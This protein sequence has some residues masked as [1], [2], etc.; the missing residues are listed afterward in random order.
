MLTQEEI[1]R[2][3]YQHGRNRS[4]KTISRNEEE[5]RANANPYA[6]AIYRRF[7]LPLADMIKK[8][9]SEKRTGR[10]QAHVQLLA[11]ID[12]LA[13]AFIAVRGVLNA[14][15]TDSDAGGR[16]VGHTV[17]A[18]VYHEYCLSVFHEA[19]P[20]LFFAITNDLG[21]RMSKS[22][23]H[24]MTVYKMSAKA[25]GVQFNEWGQG[26]VDQVG[27]YLI[28]CLEQLGMVYT[29]TGTMKRGRGFQ[30]VINVELSSEVLTIVSRISDR[31]IETTPYFLPCVEKPKPWVSLD[32]GG[33]HTKEM[34]RLHPFMIRCRPGQ[35]D[36]FRQADLSKEMECINALQETAWRVNKRLLDTVKKVSH[37]FDM[38][39]ILSMED[40]PPPERPGFLDGMKEADMS[41]DQLSQFKAWKRDMASWHTEMKLRGTRYG[42]FST[43]VRVANQFVD[44][45]EL[46][47]VYF[48]DFRGRKYV[49]TTGISPQG[50][51]LQKALLEFAKGE[52][53]DTPE[54]V[55]W[56][57]ILGANKWG[58]DKASLMD[59]VAWVDSHHDQIIQFAQDPIGNYGW[60][61]ADSPLQFLAWCFEYEQWTKF[62][63]YFLSR[64]PVSMDGTCNGLQNFSAMLRDELGGKA[65]NLV[66]SDECQDIY[67]MVAEE[68]TRLLV[69]E[70]PDENGYRD[71]WLA[72]GINRTLVKRSVMT[73]PYGSTRFSCADFING[74]YLKA[75]LAPEFSRQEYSKAA[76]YLSHIVWEAISTVVVKAREAMDWLQAA[77]RQII[78]EGH[79][80]ISWV[81]PSGFPALQTYWEQEVHRVRS[82]LC[83]GA[84]LVLMSDTDKPS[85]RKHSNG[86]APNF[87]HSMDA[88]HL[89]LTTV[90]SSTEGIHSL[91]MIHDDYG[92]HARYAGRLY[93][94]IREVFVNIYESC[95][96]LEELRSRY[97]FLPPVP[98]RGNLDINLVRESVYF[99]S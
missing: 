4:A 55:N 82:R 14:L 78:A 87:I 23:R 88:A 80:T 41:A 72:H 51:D 22:E 54:A 38:D 35:R 31:F 37:H 32:D 86:I 53:L 18:S 70:A 3:A 43:A 59:R 7:V 65:T 98:D 63:K 36:H 28:D 42:R 94:I 84:K 2:E 1:E 34:R 15:L 20:D 46:Y 24:R 69:Q 66:P 48:A 62:P 58:Y 81:S 89:T 40:F 12:P 71:K 49:Q 8:D 11:P 47:F 68:T 91:A 76:N 9:V 77:A 96:P 67:A 79:E 85:V 6:Q 97:P 27:G 90:Q 56:F 33:F 73:L 26:N 83:G 17:G 25:N 93:S 61:D 16:K 10:R 44:Y 64:L 5:G 30:H 57:K 92:T 95:D 74:D 45:D 39:E 50:S 29:S 52:P 21:R 13:V 19:E 75:G 99:F 60:K